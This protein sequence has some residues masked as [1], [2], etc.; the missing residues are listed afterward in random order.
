MVTENKAQEFR[1]AL[2][3]FATGVTVITTLDEDERPVGVTASSFNSVSLDPP[4]GIMV[5][6]EKFA[7]ERRILRQRTFCNPCFVFAARGSLKQFRTLWRG[8]ICRC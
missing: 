2:G 8:Q 4:V 3:A 7:I 1:A 6:V 5:A